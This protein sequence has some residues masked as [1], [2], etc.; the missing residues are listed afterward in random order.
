MPNSLHNEQAQTIAGPVRNLPIVVDLD[1]TLVLTDTL[2][3]TAAIALFH[4]PTGLISAISQLP[5]GR[6]ALK[7]SLAKQVSVDDLLF[8]WREDLVVWL[9]EKA[10][11]GHQ[12][13]LC[14]AADQS[15]VNVLA[16]RIGIFTSAIGSVNVNLKGDAKATYLKQRFPN[17][18]V[19]AGDHK[20]DLPIWK[21]ADAIVLAG[22]TPEI[23]RKVNQ[24]GKPI[25]KK[26]HNPTLGFK[27]FLK[28]LRV[29]HW[30]KNLL[31]FLPLVLAH[32]WNNLSLILETLLAFACLLA[33]TSATYLLNDIAD[34]STDRQHWSKR[35]RAIASGRLSVRRAFL[36]AGLLL[37]SGLCCAALLA[38]QFLVALV[39]YLV[40]TLVYSL[41]LK[42]VPLLDTLVIGVLFTTR[43]IMGAA[44]LDHP[45]PAWLLAFAVFFFFSLATAKRHTEIVRASLNGASSLKSRGY[46]I[47]D[48]PLTLA[49]GIGAAM[50]SLV[51][52]IIFV[53]QEMLPAN[54]YNR[55]EF[56]AAM[57]LLL[58]IWLGRIWLFSHR[59]R[60]NDDPVSFAI[61]DR[62]S[63]ALGIAVGI[64]F[65]IAL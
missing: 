26:F 49:L 58:A 30:T 54:T 62:P 45:K 32:E 63:L 13:H 10:A 48:G 8:P 50:A 53:L 47:E 1:K 42:K 43:L 3:E 14:S 56:L 28:A 55:P 33:V 23:E 12:I 35:H 57:P 52:L 29:H 19:Y 31:L 9:R 20:A 4:K 15:I 34:I 21:E 25:L 36:M 11:E 59:G 37:L 2:Y 41:G 40:L 16:S 22:A 46:E 27:G 5:H 60:M 38:T 44:L 6:R 18:F 64:I 39:A 17:G 61:R 51:V 24:L 65:L 7:A